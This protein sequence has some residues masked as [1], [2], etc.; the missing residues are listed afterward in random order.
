VP[1]ASLLGGTIQQRGER[2]APPKVS[3]NKST[4]REHHSELKKNA[5]KS[6]KFVINNP[7]HLGYVCFQEFRAFP[8][9]SSHFLQSKA[10]H[11][12]DYFP[13][14]KVLRR[15]LQLFS[16]SSAPETALTLF[17]TLL[18]FILNVPVVSG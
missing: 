1:E 13:S 14:V 15:T 9:A 18:N 17:K 6:F 4:P 10:L 8:S 12:L 16:L 3:P 7:N 11:P 5:M 2:Q